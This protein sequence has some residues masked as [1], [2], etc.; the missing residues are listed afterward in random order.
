MLE[1]VKGPVLG[2]LRTIKLLE[3]GLQLI[4]KL[5]VSIRNKG[6]IESDERIS[7]SNYGSRLG[8]SIEDAILEKRLVFDN[9]IVTE[10]HN[11]HA[12]T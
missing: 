6:N 3:A 10:S 8:C 2:K 1:K 9:S 4:M 11:I 5:F 12:M 7:K